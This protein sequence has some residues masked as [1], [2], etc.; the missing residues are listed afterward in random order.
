M[1][2]ILDKKEDNFLLYTPHRK[3]TEYEVK[4]GKAILVFH[5]DKVIERFI[6]WL[7]KKPTISDV[8]LDEIGTFV[9]QAIDGKRNIYDISKDM[10]SKFGAKIDNADERLIMYIRYLNRKGWIGFS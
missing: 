9:W 3:H 8:E 10:V 5:H 4:N 2:K 7:V 1:K 6:R